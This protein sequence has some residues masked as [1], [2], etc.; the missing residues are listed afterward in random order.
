MKRFESPL[1]EKNFLIFVN[2]IKS[3][4]EN[5]DKKLNNLLEVE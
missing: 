1:I 2:E 5:R 4:D 3:I